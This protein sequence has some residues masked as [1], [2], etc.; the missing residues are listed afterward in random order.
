MCRLVG[1]VGSESSGFR[2]VLHEAPRS[3]SRLSSRHPD[4][5]G[6]AVHDGHGWT[7]EKHTA[8][9]QRCARFKEASARLGGRVLVAH[10]RKGTVGSVSHRNTH[11]FV[12][13]PWV[14]AHNGTID[15]VA[16]LER[17]ASPARL[18][19]VEGDTDSERLFA[20][21]MTVIDR[22][23]EADL[24]DALA[25]AI[26]AVVARP[27]ESACN[28]LLSNG[29][30]LYAHRYDRTLYTLA[31]VPGDARLDARESHETHARLE[32]AFGRHERAVLVASE[33]ISEEPWEEVQNGTLLRIDGGRE[34]ALHVLRRTC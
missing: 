31:R 32:T 15:D 19:E 28:F 30:T 4:G 7:V 34:P 2:F 14:F 21:L 23:S 12:R 29:R 13:G 3:L 8:T 16:F 24:D 9:A 33:Q 26:A 25:D 6:I 1:I 27:G 18:A 10:V 17:G 11:P 20:Y 5:W 22:V